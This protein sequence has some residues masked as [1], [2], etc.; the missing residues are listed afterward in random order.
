[1]RVQGVTQKR[2]ITARFIGLAN[3]LDVAV[4]QIVAGKT[5]SIAAIQGNAMFA[6]APVDDAL[7]A[8]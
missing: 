2:N 6:H 4:N 7:F 5:A 8:A 1:M 3:S